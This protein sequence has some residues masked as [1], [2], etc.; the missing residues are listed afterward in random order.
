MGL[1]KAFSGAI[2]GA[3]ADQW[4]EIV[5]PDEFGEAS[6][7]VPALIQETNRW[8]GSNTRYSDGIISNGSKIFVPEGT[9]AFVFSQG[10]IEDVVAE[11]GG[12]EYHKGTPSIFDDGSLAD[13][14][15]DVLDRIG[16]GGQPSDQK[17][18]AFV[19]LRELRN[20]RFGTPGPIVYHDAGYDADLEVIA[21]GT[22]SVRVCDPARAIR[23]FVPANVDSYSLDDDR[24]RGQI[25]P[26]LVQSMTVALG[27][28]SGRYRVS[29]L[30]SH[31]S[32]VSKAVAADQDGAGSWPERFGLGLVSVAFLGISLTPDSREIVK[33]FSSKKM[34]LSALEGISQKASNIAAQQS[35][36]EGIKEHG[37]GDGAGMIFGMN[38]GAALSPQTGAQG[39]TMTVDQQLEMVK[40]L[41]ELLDAG[42]L[43]QE[44]FK[45][46]KSEILG[47]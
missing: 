42:A 40:K 5:V 9:A 29:D 31:A 34:G 37:L 41:K 26:E 33:E 22:F 35:I 36:A 19:N 18:V 10:G 15:S 12:Y 46:K 14:N 8:R 4:K 16:F 21:H 23:S 3:F 6:L 1:L 11:P 28:L 45:T 25:L 27:S 39:S 17:R 24:A 38:M 43:T 20:I 32:E 30:P 47:L 7:V 44:E 2:S 13:I